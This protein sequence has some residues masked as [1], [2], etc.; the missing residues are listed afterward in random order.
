[1]LKIA[2]GRLQNIVEKGENAVKLLLFH[3]FS[4]SLL[5]QGPLMSGLCGRV[6]IHFL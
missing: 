6:N 1:M 2:L 5:P 4:P 3:M